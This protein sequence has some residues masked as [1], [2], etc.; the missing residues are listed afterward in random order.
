MI[1]SF[2]T[3]HITLIVR[4]LVLL[5]WVPELPYNCKFIYHYISYG[6]SSLYKRKIVSIF[7][8][9]TVNDIYV[10]Y[11]KFDC[12]KGKINNCNSITIGYCSSY[13]V[14]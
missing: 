10:C 14:N 11:I 8:M 6:I 4:L 1:L 7:N 12:L 3:S 5:W 13:F 2:F 9:Y